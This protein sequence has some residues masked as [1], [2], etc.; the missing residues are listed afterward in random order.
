MQGR[1]SGRLQKLAVFF[2]PSAS[3]APNRPVIESTPN[4]DDYL[5]SAV[6]QSINILQ[7]FS[8]DAVLGEVKPYLSASRLSKPISAVSPLQEVS[9]SIRCGPRRLFRAAP[10]FLWRIRFIRFPNLAEK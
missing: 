8:E 6:P 4:G 5:P 1:P 7:A 3:V 9:G 10:A 2:T